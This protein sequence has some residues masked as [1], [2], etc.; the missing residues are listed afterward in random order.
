MAT[1]TNFLEL[2]PSIS[3]NWVFLWDEKHSINR[4]LS[5]LI[6][7][8]SGHSCS[9]WTKINLPASTAHG[10]IRFQCLINDNVITNMSN[11]Y[12][13]PQMRCR[14]AVS[15][16]LKKI[17]NWDDNSQYMEKWNMFQSPPTRLDCIVSQKHQPTFGLTCPTVQ[18][19]FV[20]DVAIHWTDTLSHG[21]HN[22]SSAL[23]A[24]IPWSQWPNVITHQLF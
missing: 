2:W 23:L 18:Q 8:I 13:N 17:V 9:C 11:N 21:C 12:E 6:T 20:H 5:V 7:G 3:S 4:V 14:L 16:P 1:T 10:R 22:N 19:L 24:W 15:T